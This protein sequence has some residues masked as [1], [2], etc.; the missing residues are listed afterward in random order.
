[1]QLGDENSNKTFSVNV[2][3]FSYILV[4]MLI[5]H[6]LCRNA[7]GKWMTH[8]Y[9]VQFLCGPPS[10]LN[11]YKNMTDTTDILYTP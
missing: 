8:V 6:N 11:G 3:T 7:E 4:L 10:F 5:S 9:K 2:K 1:M